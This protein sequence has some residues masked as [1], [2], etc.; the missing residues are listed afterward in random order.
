MPDV[1]KLLPDAIANQI[2]A[3][4]VIQRPASAVKELLENAIDAGA[5]E[6]R[7]IVKDAGKNLIQVI[8]NGCGMSP[9]DARMSFERHATS[10]IRKSDDLFQI[11][12]MGFRGEALASI[13]AIAQVEMKSRRPEDEVGTEIFIEASEVKRQEPCQM[14]PGT[15]IAIRNLF[16]NT[17]ARRQFLKSNNVEMRHIIDEFQRV[18][19][20]FP[21]LSFSLFHNSMELFNLPPGTLRKRII[22]LFGNSYNERLV[23]VDESTDVV[24]IN[25]FIGKP[26]F[27]RK[28]RGE[29][30]F[31]VNRRFIKSPYLHHAI[32]SA[33]DDLLPEK[34]YPLYV[35]FLQLDPAG[36]DINV[37]PTK[38]EV[39]FQD[40]RII[41]AYL[42]S[43]V[44]RALGKYSVTPSLDFENEAGIEKSA[45]WIEAMQE[46]QSMQPPP[47]KRQRDEVYNPFYPGG[48][49]PSTDRDARWKEYF[50]SDDT[51]NS[52]P[53]PDDETI[54][55]PS[56]WDRAAQND[57]AEEIV[58]VQIH[59]SY[60]LAT[61]KD[62]LILL[63][64]QAAHER[65]LYERFLDSLEKNKGFTQ[66][67]LFPVTIRLSTQD[68]V[69][70]R[71][72]LDD[73]NALGFEL[74][75][76]GEND[77][78]IHGLPADIEGINE[79][80]VIEGL[81]EQYKAARESLKLN[82]RELLAR[83]M[84]R[85]MATKRGRKL[86]RGEMRALIDE[87]FACRDYL[88]APNGNR[89]FI[90]YSLDELQRQ[91]EK[92]R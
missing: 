22:K 20:A 39:K 46:M 13:A 73:V 58:P 70:L 79:K 85:Q 64:Q 83:A 32:R 43:A 27:A 52:N 44:K 1:I 23:P 24:R 34:A 71:N 4:E 42:Q 10:K 36:I 68:A 47:E 38:Q 92:K 55:V 37:H 81:L 65:I 19:L 41:Y 66:K 11:R 87:L 74:R 91:F 14:M 50:E 72:I 49:Q 6:I 53:A 12:T 15:S 90:K 5:T 9:T 67:Q 21:Q 35:V 84:A 57:A 25:G 54:T 77:F 18:A 28:T 63:D 86:G 31:F 8:D 78:V 62:G 3:G 89:T 29:Q 48:R 16:F 45:K 88:T 59:A 75:H 17:P 33:F 69:L 56:G 82:K 40:E 76:F 80:E 60:I 7:L 51:E 61:I 30:Y 2:A 26:E